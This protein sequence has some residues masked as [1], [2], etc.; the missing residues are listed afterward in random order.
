MC[1]SIGLGGL[2][3]VMGLSGS[4]ML[5]T[6]LIGAWV[7]AVI[8]IPKVYKIGLEKQMTT[9]PQLFNHYYNGKVA[10]AAGVISAINYGIY[11]FANT[12]RS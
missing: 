5:F 1:F 6:G 9:F 7:S 12:C 3:F 8:L 11:E 2:G 10:L 4:W